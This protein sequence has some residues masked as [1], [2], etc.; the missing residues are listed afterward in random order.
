MHRAVRLDFDLQPT[1][2]PPS[3]QVS[4]P[5]QGAF[6]MMYPTVNLEILTSEVKWNAPSFKWMRKPAFGQ[7]TAFGLSTA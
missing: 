3:F 4:V 5:V 2:V 6:L 7:I 1:E